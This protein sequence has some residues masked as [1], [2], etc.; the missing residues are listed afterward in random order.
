[1]NEIKNAELTSIGI[2]GRQYD[3]RPGPEFLG[4]VQ[5]RNEV[6]HLGFG[7]PLK[8]LQIV[9]LRFNLVIGAVEPVPFVSRTVNTEW[10]ANSITKLFGSQFVLARKNFDSICYLVPPLT[11]T[12]NRSARL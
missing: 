9:Q 12:L 10:S 6:L 8:P 2:E 5:S 4:H 7:D 1:M 3:F 11:G